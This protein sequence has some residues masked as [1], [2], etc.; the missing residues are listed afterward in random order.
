MFVFNK[1]IK[2]ILLNIFCFVYDVKTIQQVCCSEPPGGVICNFF[3][4]KNWRLPEFLIKFKLHGSVADSHT[5][6]IY[7]SKE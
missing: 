4:P 6:A 3:A 7:D 2:N 1:L 5:F